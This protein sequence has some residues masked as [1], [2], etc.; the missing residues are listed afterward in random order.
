MGNDWDGR[1]QWQR[2]GRTGPNG[3]QYA[4][5][6]DRNLVRRGRGDQVGQPRKPGLIARIFGGKKG[7]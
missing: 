2:E 4:S 5:R 1:P 3:P 6:Q 7:K